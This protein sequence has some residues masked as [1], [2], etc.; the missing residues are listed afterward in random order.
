M[1]NLTSNELV[2]IVTRLITQDVEDVETN[3]N[4]SGDSIRM[5]A[6][7][8]ANTVLERTDSALLRSLTPTSINAPAGSAL[9][10]LPA[11]F[12]AH[13]QLQISEDSGTTWRTLEPASFEYLFKQRP[14][15]ASETGSP[16]QYLITVNNG[17]KIQLVPGL[18]SAITNGLR[19]VFT[20]QASFNTLADLTGTTVYAMALDGSG[21]LFMSSFP[22]LQPTLIPF[23]ACFHAL[24]HAGKAR[25]GLSEKYMTLFE[26]ELQRFHEALE[27]LTL[28][29]GGY[30]R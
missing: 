18:D 19:A 27:N 9:A 13:L 7:M 28:K 8:A 20:A 26:L 22:Q 4:F 30:V 11:S 29:F 5:Y 6:T 12:L 15:F 1:A 17:P 25:W 16:Q 21:P 10:D 24:R 3:D 2:E 14:G 23:M